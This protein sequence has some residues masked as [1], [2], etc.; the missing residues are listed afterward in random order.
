MTDSGVEAVRVH[1]ERFGTPLLQAGAPQIEIT[2]DT[3]AA[4]LEVVIDGK[5]LKLCLPYEGVSVL[6]VGLKAGLALALR[7]QR[8]CVLHVP[9]ESAR[10]RSEDEQ[11]LHPGTTRDR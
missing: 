5:K 3:P 6:D 1:V 8:W 2:E 11:E 4:D 9:R 10:R 7:V